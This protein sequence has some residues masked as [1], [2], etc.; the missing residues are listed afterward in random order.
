MGAVALGQCQLVRI[1]D[2][3]SLWVANLF[4]QLFYGYGGGR[5]AAP[6]HIETALDRCGL[7]AE[8]YT[9]PIYMP[10][11]GCGRGGLNWE[12]E[13]KQIVDGVAEKHAIDIYVCEF[14]QPYANN[15]NK[16]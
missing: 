14:G 4:T 10:K 3:D 7:Y 9:L 12:A 1:A 5:Y 15:S 2:D 13:V 6:E 11:I 8:M 16:Q